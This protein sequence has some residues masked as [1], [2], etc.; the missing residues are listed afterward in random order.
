MASNRGAAMDFISA[1]PAKRPIMK[2]TACITKYRAAARGPRYGCTCITNRMTKLPTPTCVK[3]EH[4]PEF[5][6]LFCIS[7]FGE[8]L[9][10]DPQI[11]LVEERLP[12]IIHDLPSFHERARS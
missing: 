3:I 5:R 12:P 1:E 8:D 10:P 2:P 6:S 9:P 4:R 11:V 7:L